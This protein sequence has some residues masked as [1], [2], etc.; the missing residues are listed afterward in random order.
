MQQSARQAAPRSFLDALRRRHGNLALP[1]GGNDGLRV[2]VLADYGEPRGGAQRIVS[3]LGI[4]E[5]LWAPERERACLVEHHHVGFG[6]ALKPIRSLDDDAPPEQ[7]ARR[8]DLHR[9]HGERERARTSDDEHGDGIGQ[10]RL[11]GSA[12]QHPADEGPGAKH[13][14]RRR[15]TRA[16]RSARRR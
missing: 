11:P 14:H 10:S 1:R 8:R 15:I 4:V 6:G 7:A 12:K 16:A 2:R 3:D 13:M 9:R 5:K